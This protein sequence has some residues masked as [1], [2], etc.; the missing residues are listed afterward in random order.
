MYFGDQVDHATC[1][2]DPFVV[3]AGLQGSVEAWPELAVAAQRNDAMSC[4]PSESW[5]DSDTMPNA[6]WGSVVFGSRDHCLRHRLTSFV[7]MHA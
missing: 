1:N 6:A 3:G 2:L 5:A 7:I 4:A